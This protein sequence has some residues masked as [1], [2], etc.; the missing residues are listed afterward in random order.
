MRGN[1]VKR[2][3]GLRPPEFQSLIRLSNHPKGEQAREA[4]MVEI[5]VELRLIFT[6]ARAGSDRPP[7]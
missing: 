1:R 2:G 7:N 5:I 3:V 6:A 4:A